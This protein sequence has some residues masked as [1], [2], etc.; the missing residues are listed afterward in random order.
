MRPRPVV[1]KAT[2]PEAVRRLL[3]KFEYPDRESLQQLVPILPTLGA[4]GGVGTYIH[5]TRNATQSIASAGEPISWD[6]LG[7]QGFSGFTETVPT[8]TVTITQAGYYNIAVQLGWSSFTG[9]GTITVLKNGLVVWAPSDDPGLW[10]STYGRF[11]EGTAHA[12]ECKVGDTLSVNV[13]PDDAS[14]QTLTSATLTT[15]LVDRAANEGLYRELVLSHGPV[16]Y[17][18]LDETS[19]SAAADETG[20]G[21]DG[22]YVDTPTLDQSG[23]MRDG[24]GSPSVDFDGANEYVSVPIASV[25]GLVAVS[26]EAWINF[27]TGLGASEQYGIFNVN[28]DGSSGGGANWWGLW[29]DE[30]LKVFWSERDNTKHISNSALSIASTHYIAATRSATGEFKLYIDGAL[31]LTVSGIDTDNP[32]TGQAQIAMDWDVAAGDTETDH[33]DGRIDEVAV[34][35]RVLSAVEILEHYEVGRSAL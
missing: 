27:D 10:S 31:D 1:G 26:V 14:A 18:R 24:S 4:A 13:N 7:L 5:L 12:I 9:G 2:V 23:V 3:D 19:G 28:D 15:Y 11:F 8:T 22:T 29:V 30:D 20:N 34:Y 16:A 35:D 6:A 32:G 33:F 21:H 17:W 25:Q